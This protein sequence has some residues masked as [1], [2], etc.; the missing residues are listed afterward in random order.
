MN[1]SVNYA[2]FKDKF[3]PIEAANVNIKTH[4]F[5]YGTAIFEGIR[6]Y[7]NPS[8]H[9]LYVF[10]LK[11]H[12]ARMFDNMKLF[13]F[14]SKYT[15]EEVFE[16]IVD[17]LKKN[18]PKQD[19][20]IRPCAYSSALSIGPGL[21]DNPSDICIFTVPFGDYYNN[22]ALRVQVSAWR[23]VEDNAIPSRAKIIGAYANT[24]LAKTDAVRAGFDECIMLT[25]SGHVAEGSAMNVFL[26]KGGKLITPAATDNILEGITLGTVIEIAKEQFGLETVSRSVDRS[27]LYLADE[28]FFCGT[29]AQIVAIGEVDGR[30]I[31]NGRPGTITTQI[32]DTY[33]DICRGNFPQ[34]S[35]WL[36]PVYN[37]TNGKS[38]GSFVGKA[39]FS[40]NSPVGSNT[41]VP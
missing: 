33:I 18:L 12:I 30:P 37:S 22:A 29:G 4:A 41:F 19:T 34:Y 17:L 23:R 5:M 38:D 27:E 25:E 10:R 3:V 24:A 13:Y 40:T 2:F 35:K 7:W 31:G 14:E 1:R 16:I 28:L 39:G 9:E 26:V 11:E 6:G 20:Y 21:M 15:Q 32:R 8:K 36:T